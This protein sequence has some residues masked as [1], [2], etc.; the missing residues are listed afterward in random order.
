VSIRTTV[1]LDEDLVARVIEESRLSGASFDETVHALLRRALAR[2]PFKVRPMSLGYHPHLN[3]DKIEAL[4]EYAE[5][6]FHR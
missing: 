4:I 5:G 1:T 6:P 3:Y 2:R